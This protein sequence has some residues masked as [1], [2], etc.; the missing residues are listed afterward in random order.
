MHLQDNA[1]TSIYAT[2]AL[3]IRLHL[4]IIWTLQVVENL[5]YKEMHAYFG[6]LVMRSYTA[7]DST[8]SLYH[9]ASLSLTCCR[10]NNHIFP[11][12]V[13][14]TLN[15]LSKSGQQRKLFATDRDKHLLLLHNNK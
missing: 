3:R 5:D 10:D 13:G 2:S 1:G 8:A 12:E 9:L 6:M 11:T 7:S 4:F 15:E 14:S